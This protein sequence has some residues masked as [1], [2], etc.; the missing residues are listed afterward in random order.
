MLVADSGA[1]A[2][3][4]LLRWDPGGFAERELADRQALRFPPA[5]RLAALT[6]AGDALTDLLARAKLPP[7]AEVLGPVPVAGSLRGSGDGEHRLLIRV[8]RSHGAALAQGLRAAQAV[9]TAHKAPDHVRIQID[10]L[11]IG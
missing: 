6:G 4:A 2:V 11:D 8:P 1:P 7:G 9:R 5:V 3:Q 10:P